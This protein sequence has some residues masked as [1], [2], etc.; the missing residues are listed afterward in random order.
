MKPVIL[1]VTGS[2]TGV[3]KTVF[4]SLLT[5]YLCA[6]GFR[7]AGLKPICSGGR[8]DAVALHLA[9]GKVLALD[10][11]NPWHFRAPIA[12]LLA[13]RREHRRVTRQQ[14]TAHL[15]AVA[16]SFDA[17]VV[18]GA[19]GLL[20]PLGPG[21]DSRDLIRALRAM[22]VIVCASR[23]GAV[24]QA[25]LV[26]N[27]LPRPAARRAQIVLMSP[28][29]ANFASR[30]NPPLLRE[31]AGNTPVY[32]LPHLHDPAA[33]DAA[34]SRSPVRQALAALLREIEG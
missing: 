22:P 10:E 19:G 23:L 26:L 28:A 24:N 4:A 20:S 9:A 32:Q 8:G 27:A 2:D 30:T 29:R 14:V 1:F 13:A 3:G 5:R 33:L 21:F 25:L 16:K 7:V 17:V 15:R 6:R 31:L 34:L 12:P 11:V 18:E